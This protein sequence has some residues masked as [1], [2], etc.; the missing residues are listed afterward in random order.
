[1]WSL[2]FLSVNEA[3]F[4]LYSICIILHYTTCCM[5]IC[6]LSAFFLQGSIMEPEC[7]GVAWRWLCTVQGMLMDS[8]FDE[9][10]SM[11]YTF[12]LQKLHTS[13][14]RWRTCTGLMTMVS[15]STQ[16]KRLSGEDHLKGKPNATRSK[17]RKWKRQDLHS[18]WSN[19]WSFHILSQ[20]LPALNQVPLHLYYKH[21]WCWPSWDETYFTVK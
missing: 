10:I 8:S 13:G 19:P 17:G 9:C 1:M 2:K 4:P 15:P 5:Y 12:L 18:A 20:I 7:H 21:W 16:R 11:K 14:K 6:P 3:Q